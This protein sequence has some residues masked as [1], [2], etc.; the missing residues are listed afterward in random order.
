MNFEEYYNNIKNQ[1]WADNIIISL[2]SKYYNLEIRIIRYDNNIKNINTVHYGNCIIWLLLEYYSNNTLIE[3]KN[4]YSGLIPK[5]PI[6]SG[7]EISLNSIKN[8][9][10]CDIINQIDFNKKF[11][12]NLNDFNKIEIDTNNNNCLFI[13]FCNLLGINTNY[14]KI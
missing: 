6:N 8:N 1:E 5:N 13:A 10:I 9:I 2:I 4:H 12:Y 11:K 7:D 14:S 3:I